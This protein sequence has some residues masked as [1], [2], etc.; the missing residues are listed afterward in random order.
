MELFHVVVLVAAALCALVAGLLFTF[1]V[2]SMPGLENLS[3]REF[4]RAFQVMD[5]VIQDRQPLFMVVWVGSVVALLLALAMGFQQEDGVVR[6]LLIV[7]AA[8]YLFGV[9]LPTARVHI[10]L[11]NE[12]QTVEVEAIG[13]AE[14]KQARERFEGRWNRSNRIRTAIAV[15]TM[16][17]L[18]V[19]LV[20]LPVA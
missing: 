5:R 14:Q 19:V 12:I 7:A 16:V 6:G 2:V 18:L 20:R 13:E 11:N 15:V 10:P 4:I 1:A 9:Q 3:D 8:L 17:L